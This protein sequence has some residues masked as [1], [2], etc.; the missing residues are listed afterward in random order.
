MRTLEY[1]INKNKHTCVQLP[2]K[3]ST[4]LQINN[5]LS[6][7]TTDSERQ[8]VLHNL[9]LDTLIENL[10]TTID[11]YKTDLE[12]QINSISENVSQDFYSVGSQ[13]SLET[14]IQAIPTKQKK[15][16]L[17][18]TFKTSD[19]WQWYQYLG[20]SILNWNDPTQNWKKLNFCKENE[21]ITITSNKTYITLSNHAET[22]QVTITAKDGFISGGSYYT[23]KHTTPILF[24]NLSTP[25]KSVTVLVDL[26]NDSDTI[27]TA[28][29]KVN[30]EIITQTYIFKIQYPV[31]IKFSQN[32]DYT[33]D[34]YWASIFLNSNDIVRNNDLS[35]TKT[36]NNQRSGQPL[37]VIVPKQYN[38]SIKMNGF[39]FPLESPVDIPSQYENVPYKIYKSSN[40]YDE[41]NYPLVITYSI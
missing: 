14:A 40:T 23:D 24:P 5:Y 17:V 28:K 8:Q 35:T 16:G 21:G 3:I 13:E 7:Y 29:A 2:Q 38:V 31:W 26:N 1:Y 36:I 6:E 4:C 37:F 11:N 18:I 27:F 19:G 9:G 10:Q 22:A 33:Q 30:G 25:V 20:S 12:S 39:D 32:V 34:T 15:L 41:G